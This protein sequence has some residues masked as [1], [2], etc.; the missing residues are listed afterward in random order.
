MQNMLTADLTGAGSFVKFFLQNNYTG[1]WEAWLQTAY[2][3]NIVMQFGGSDF[4][5]EHRY[6]APNNNLICDI[7]VETRAPIYIELKVKRNK[8]YTQ[9]VTSFGQ[10]I[11]KM[12]G[13]NANTRASSICMAMA[14]LTLGTGDQQNLNLFRTRGP[15]GVPKY[16]CYGG[17]SQWADVTGTILSAPNDGLILATYK[18][19]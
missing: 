4:D 3:R 14:V 6:P 2:A 13:L 19:T 17:G 7:W 12:A 8:S 1:G 11:T 9:A 15:A 16:L 18:L 10:D 5:R